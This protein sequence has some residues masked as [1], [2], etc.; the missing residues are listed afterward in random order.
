MNPAYPDLTDKHYDLIA[1][2]MLEV[3]KRLAAEGD[4]ARIQT[5]RIVP[6]ED[7]WYEWTIF[8]EI[9]VPD[10]YYPELPPLEKSDRHFDL[11]QEQ[12]AE[13]YIPQ[14]FPIPRHYSPSD[15]LE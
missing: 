13:D 2:R 1:E 12:F 15:L 9:L 4:P 7:C 14:F 10:D 11:L 5:Y 8:V 6:D 3:N